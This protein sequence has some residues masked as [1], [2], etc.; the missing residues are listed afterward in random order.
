MV[1]LSCKTTPFL[2]SIYSSISEVVEACEIA[3]SNRLAVPGWTFFE[4]F[5]AGKEGDCSNYNILKV[6]IAYCTSSG[7]PVGCAMLFQGWG[8]TN[9]GCFVRDSHRR[10]GIGA[11]L[12]QELLAGETTP[13]RIHEGAAGSMKFWR[14]VGANNMDYIEDKWPT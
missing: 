13:V 1:A 12:V 14:S 8:D 11:R 7:L 6:S 9:A 3:A 2:Y 5:R 4:I 10:Q